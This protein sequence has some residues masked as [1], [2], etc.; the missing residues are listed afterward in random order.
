MDYDEVRPTDGAGIDPRS[1]I[2]LEMLILSI[3]EKLNRDSKLY[4]N[5]SFANKLYELNIVFIQRLINI[6]PY[7][8]VLVHGFLLGYIGRIFFY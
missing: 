1:S 5:V 8:G 2:I 4:R 6:N 3:I 7:R